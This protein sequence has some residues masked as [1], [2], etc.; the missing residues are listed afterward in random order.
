MFTNLR[1]NMLNIEASSPKN[2]PLE[3][4]NNMNIKNG[5]VIADIGS[6]GGYFT[7]KFSKAAGKE[8]KI[9]SVDTNQKTLNYITQKARKEKLN[10]IKTIHTNENGLILPEM[11]DILFLRNVF[12]L[13]PQLDEYFKNIKQFIK[14]DGKI[15]LIEHK[16]KG[17]NFVGIFGHYTSEEV[18]KDKM[19]KA[20]YRTY[21]KFD[22]LPNQSF[23]IFKMK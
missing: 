10:N 12:H 23:T 18:I 2:K 8:G 11:V 22:F 5:D 7:F 21:K 20:G 15:V 16:I 17:F 19:E 9:Y 3:I 4:I 13:L 6:G 1:V 14:N